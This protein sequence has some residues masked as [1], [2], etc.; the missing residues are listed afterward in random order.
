MATSFRARENRASSE[1]KRAVTHLLIAV[2]AFGVG[3]ATQ[4]PVTKLEVGERAYREGRTGDAEQIWLE[5][6]AEAE[7]YGEDDP[8]LAQM[9]P[10][11][12]QGEASL[13]TEAHMEVPCREDFFLLCDEGEVLEDE[14]G[15]QP[16]EVGRTQVQ[17]PSEGLKA[18]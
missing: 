16:L 11:R 18:C 8:R 1:G 7:A 10:G 5:T 9:D 3:C 15:L 6:L 12:D 2:L 14:A 4:Y 13:P 17:L